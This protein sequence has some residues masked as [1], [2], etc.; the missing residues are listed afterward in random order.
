MNIPRL[1]D[2]K[3]HLKKW[4]FCRVRWSYPCQK[5]KVDPKKWPCVKAFL[6]TFGGSSSKG[7]QFVAVCYLIH[8]IYMLIPTCMPFGVLLKMFNSK[9]SS[10]GSFFGKTLKTWSLLIVYWS[11]TSWM[12]AL[13]ARRFQECI[14]VTYISLYIYIYTHYTH[15]Q[16]LQPPKQ[17]KGPVSH[18]R[19]MT[20]YFN[21]Y[22][23]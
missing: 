19:S 6:D 13:F 1:R 11:R 14:Y 8:V 21:C 15:L 23:K 18:H 2:F 20:P 22:W 3:D 9:S 7:I 16:I 17:A 4:L 12:I 10:K 5:T